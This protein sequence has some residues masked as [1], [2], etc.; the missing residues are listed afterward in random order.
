MWEQFIEISAISPN[1]TFLNYQRMHENNCGAESEQFSVLSFRFYFI[2]LLY[3]ANFVNSGVHCY[4]CHGI[5]I[6][7][8]SF[9]TICTGKI[10]FHFFL[11]TYTIYHLNSTI[12][13][14]RHRG[15]MTFPSIAPE[16]LTIGYYSQNRI[17]SAL[18]SSNE[19]SR[20]N[21]YG[22]LRERYSDRDDE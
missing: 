6:T 11:R 12:I 2:S 19:D 21:G 18:L 4:H 14:D 13:L 20:W 8:V 3:V 5:I 17:P 15:P 10:V 9:S 7:V 22:R 16:L 1:F